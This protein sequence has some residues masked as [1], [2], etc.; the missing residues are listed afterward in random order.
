MRSETPGTCTAPDCTRPVKFRAVCGPHYTDLLAERPF[1]PSH[2]LQVRRPAVAVPAECREESC[3]EPG[4]SRELCRYHYGVDL[5]RHRDPEAPGPRP[6]RRKGD[7]A[8]R[9][10]AMTGGY[11]RLTL[12]G[13]DGRSY[14]IAEHRYVMEQHLGRP[15]AE[16]EN[17]HHLNGDRADNRL[18]NLELWNTAQPK[19][20]RPADKVDFALEIL[21]QYAPEMLS[22]NS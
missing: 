14:Q 22:S 10:G 1:R 19:G 17:V 16:H 5:R 3:S 11:V 2:T 7:T 15:L 4:Y 12:L 6:R 20:Q 21:Q 13:E 18:E 9:R 8:P